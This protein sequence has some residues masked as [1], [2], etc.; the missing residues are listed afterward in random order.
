MNYNGTP[1]IAKVGEQAIFHFI[2][3]LSCTQ[4]RSRRRPPCSFMVEGR[5]EV[6]HDDPQFADT[7]WYESIETW[8]EGL[9][10]SPAS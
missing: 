7:N 2:S 3:V 5:R 9:G 4:G 6:P 1:V 10:M 8:E